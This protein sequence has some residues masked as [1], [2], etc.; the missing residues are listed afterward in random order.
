MSLFGKKKLYKVVWQYDEFCIP[1]TEIVAAKDPAHAWK[2]IKKQ[3][4]LLTGL[5]S[6]EIIDMNKLGG[7][8][9]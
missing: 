8:V 2:K 3:Y 6:L 1:V 4:S 9:E 7:K 5:I